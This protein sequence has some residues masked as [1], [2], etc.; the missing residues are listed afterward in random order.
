MNRKGK[1]MN[2]K[3]FFSVVLSAFM[4]FIFT[5]C[6][7][8]N[9]GDRANNP[10]NMNQKENT[11]NEN[12][13][14]ANLNRPVVIWNYNQDYTFDQKDQLKDN[15]DNAIDNLDDRIDKMQDKVDSTSKQTQNWYNDKIK[16]IKQKRDA[17]NDQIDKIDDTKRADWDKFQAN[18]KDDW[19]NLQNSWNDVRMH[20]A[21]NTNKY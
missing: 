3:I 11:T 8:R 15:L 5:S 13:T 21:S 1:I 18:L 9:E 16:D 2:T 14:N 4:I 10:G 7:N 12:N 6:Q 19:N 20:V 17:F